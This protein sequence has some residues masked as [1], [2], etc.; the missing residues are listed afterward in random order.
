MSEMVERVANALWAG[1]HHPGTLLL[2][3]D[4]KDKQ[5]LI[6]SARLAIEAMRE[7]TDAMFSAAT[8]TYC[9]AGDLIDYWHKMIDE[10]AK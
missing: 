10:A 6:Y 1:E 5:R 4:G 8:D 3:L 9:S 7:P 2:P